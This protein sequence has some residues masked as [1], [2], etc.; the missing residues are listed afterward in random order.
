MALKIFHGRMLKMKMMRVILR[1]I[2][3]RR[4]VRIRTPS[5]N[6]SFQSM[7]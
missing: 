3:V 6:L 5:K 4:K 7:P 1:K 2:M